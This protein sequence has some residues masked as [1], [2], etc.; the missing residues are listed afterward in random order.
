MIHL[1]Y[2]TKSLYGGERQQGTT[3]MDESP[4]D[5]DAKHQKDANNIG[6]ELLRGRYP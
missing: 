5:L 4:C 1:G 2:H 3:Y 6:N